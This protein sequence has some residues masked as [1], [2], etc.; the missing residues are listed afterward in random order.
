MLRIRRIAIPS[1]ISIGALAGLMSLGTL[2][3]SAQALQ[4]SQA[5]HLTVPQSG[6]VPHCSGD[7]CA[8]W[9]SKTSFKVRIEVWAFKTN[10]TGH[11]ELKTPAGTHFNSTTKAWRAGGAGYDVTVALSS[12]KY[13]A[14]AWKNV[15]SGKFRNIGDVTFTV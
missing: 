5:N 3:A 1:L 10:F 8:K 11:F 2:P 6:G 12:G 13:E 4:A 15:S 9:L 7:V 14:I